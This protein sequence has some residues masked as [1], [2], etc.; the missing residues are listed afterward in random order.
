MLFRREKSKKAT[1]A[2]PLQ[3]LDAKR[4]YEVRF[5]DTPQRQTVTGATLSALPVEIPSAPG[6]SIV[7]YR[8]TD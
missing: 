6:S 4:R 8:P 7:Y 2:V 3:E 1:M 5:E